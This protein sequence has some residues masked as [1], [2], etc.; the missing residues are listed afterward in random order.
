MVAWESPGVTVTSVG[1]SGTTSVNDPDPA[2]VTGSE[3]ADCTL[4][5]TPVVVVAVKT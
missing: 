2:G 5:P 1:G 4:V 3:G